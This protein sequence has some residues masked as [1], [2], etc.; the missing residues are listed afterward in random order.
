MLLVGTSRDLADLDGQGSLAAG[1][2]VTAI[3]A[4]APTV[5]GGGVYVLTDRAR[6]ARVER[7]GLAPVATLPAADA[8]SM[9]LADGR[10]VVGRAAAHLATVD[11][12]GGTVRS[13]EA[14]DS[15]AG[16]RSWKNPAGPSPDVRSV[17]A[18]PG[19]TWLV[20]IH[21]GGVWRSTDAGDTW[22]DVVAPD[23]D[24]HEVAA[25]R[26]GIVAVASAVGFGWSVDDGRSWQWT[27]DG[28]HDVY[29][30]AVALDGDTV[31]LSASTGPTTRDGRL[32]RGRLGGGFE[33]CAG[34]LP[35][36]FPFNIET[37]TV[38]AAGGKVAVGLPTGEVWR[39]TDAGASF[40]RV[41]E[42]VGRVQ[43]LRF[44]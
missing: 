2:D 1:V 26:D 25:G 33:Q 16:R 7:S 42:R 8:Q 22:R 17:A 19:G 13:L 6:I 15:V 29:C 30:R 18:S 28:L 43:V 14:F 5:P 39:S 32:Y 35:D 23:A 12:Q 44:A 9:A 36:S 31:Y 38:A 40:R 21:V 27:R 20:N 10:L 4:G 3:A 24:V 37:A 41:A 11:L 34:G